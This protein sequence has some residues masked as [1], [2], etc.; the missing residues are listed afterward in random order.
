LDIRI[1]GLRLCGE[2]KKVYL[3]D[4][5]FAA[6]CY[7]YNKVCKKAEKNPYPIVFIVD[8]RDLKYDLEAKPEFYAMKNYGDMTLALLPHM[9]FEYS[10]TIDAQKLVGDFIP[11]TG[12]Q[13]LSMLITILENVPD[14]TF[15]EQKEIEYLQKLLESS[16][17]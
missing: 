5:I 6:Y 1:N 4:N 7:A 8:T 12:P 15:E 17:E 14:L 2:D 9:Q 10:R 13:N 16:H 3:T 11:P